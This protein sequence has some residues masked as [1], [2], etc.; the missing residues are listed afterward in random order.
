MVIFPCFRLLVSGLSSFLFFSLFFSQQAAKVFQNLYTIFKQKDATQIEINPMGE[1][2]DGTIL[3]MDAKF[4][5]DDNA[6]FRQKDVFALR[7]I[8]QEDKG[9]VDAAE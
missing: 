6:E 2:A 7:D 1:L 4:G 8:S 9:E 5:F 3:C